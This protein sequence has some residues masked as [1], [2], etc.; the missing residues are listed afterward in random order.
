MLGPEVA[1]SLQNLST[2]LPTYKKVQ[3]MLWGL[4]LVTEIQVTAINLRGYKNKM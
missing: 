4:I 1:L 2:H 3:G